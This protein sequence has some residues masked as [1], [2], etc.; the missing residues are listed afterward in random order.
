M[1]PSPIGLPVTELDTPAL[2]VDLDRLEHNIDLMAGHFR[3]R[4]VAWR[5]HAKGRKM[6][7]DCPHAPPQGGHRGDRREGLR[8]GGHG[9]G[10]DRRILVAH[11]VVGHRRRPGWPPCSG[12]PRSRRAWTIPTRSNRWACAA[13]AAGVEI[14]VLVDVDLGMRRTGVPDA[15]SALA[16]AWKVSRTRGYGS[17]G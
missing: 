6:P 5:P 16:L 3:E 15:Q 17:K 14:G 4:G 8:G 13:I 7:G 11:L 2:L 1:Q 10:G 9:G 12:A